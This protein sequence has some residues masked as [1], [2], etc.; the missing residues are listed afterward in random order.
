MNRYTI[1]ALALVASPAFATCPP[2]DN[3]PYPDCLKP[4]VVTPPTPTQT[5]TGSLEQNQ[6]QA[7]GQAQGQGQGQIATGGSGTGIGLGVGQGGAGGQGG[8]S[9][10]IAA[11][12]KGGSSDQSQIAFSGANNVTDVSTG[13]SAFSDQTSSQAVTNTNGGNTTASSADGSGNAD[14]TIGGDQYEGSQTVFQAAM[15]SAPPV[16]GPGSVAQVS[17]G[18]CGPYMGVSSE[19]VQGT[20]IGLFRK[21]Q[22]YLGRSDRIVEYNGESFR[23]KRFPDGRWYLEGQR[24]VRTTTVLNVSGSRQVSLGGG[25]TGGGYGQAGVGG[26]SSMQRLVTQIDREPCVAYI[27]QAAQVPVIEFKEPRVPRG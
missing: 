26:G 13:A 1:L 9:S 25:D 3:R 18:Q 10:A 27:E 12:G 23:Q 8:A 6:G 17:Y 7:Q 20:Y 2:G 24:A 22:I 14:V 19:D 15:P 4:P 5:Q 11:G 16:F 21:Q